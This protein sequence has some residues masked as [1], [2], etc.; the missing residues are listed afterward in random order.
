MPFRF[1]VWQAAA[2]GELVGALGVGVAAGCVA[3]AWVA[4]GCVA[5]AWVAAGWVAAGGAVM[6]MVFT[7]TAAVGELEQAQ[8]IRP[9]TATAPIRNG[10]IVVDPFG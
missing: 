3:G 5:G 6:V 7:G 1:L 10:F 9:I 8:V 4:G 2:T